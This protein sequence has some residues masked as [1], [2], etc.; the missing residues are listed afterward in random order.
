MDSVEINF[1]SSSKTNAKFQKD[2]PDI[3][4]MRSRIEETFLLVFVK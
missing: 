2:L 1:V 3:L 4:G